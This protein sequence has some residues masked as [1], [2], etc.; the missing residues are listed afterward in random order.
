MLIR[1]AHDNKKCFL[2]VIR[3]IDEIQSQSNNLSSWEVRVINEILK[4]YSLTY[5]VSMT[6]C[7]IFEKPL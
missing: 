7:A 1:K 6:K 3:S 5:F 2:E 4:I